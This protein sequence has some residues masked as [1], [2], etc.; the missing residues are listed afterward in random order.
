M[1]INH[2]LLL[3]FWILF[4]LIH[5]AL[6]TSKI[7]KAILKRLKIKQTTYRIFYNLIAFFTL[8]LI[9]YYQLKIKSPLLIVPS[10]IIYIISGLIILTGIT[11]MVI[12]MKKYFKQMAGLVEEV[13]IL[14]ISGIHKFV[15]HPL[16]LGTFL[17][18]IG[19]FLAFPLLSNLIGTCIIIIYTLIGIYFE[20]KKL[21]KTFGSSYI[22]YKQ[23]VPMIIP[24]TFK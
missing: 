8:F 24:H 7:K 23:K 13:P 12:C 14:E 20:E 6:A 9:I 17:F 19:L 15:R 2:I 22:S 11:I 18:V 3:I 5:S 10:L 4:G 1:I 21:I 16:Y